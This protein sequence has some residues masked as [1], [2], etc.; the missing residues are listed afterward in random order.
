MHDIKSSNVLLPVHDDTCS[1]HVTPTSD[2]NNVAGVELDIIGDFALLEVELDCVVDPDQG[3]GV[4]DSSAVVRDDM[5]DTLGTNGY[6]ADLQELVR[7]FLRCDAMDSE[8]AFDIV[9]ETEV[10]AR[11]L[12]RNDIYVRRL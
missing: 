6:P 4:A 7:G 10:L 12:N 2:H 9:E 3:V 11:F 8:P 1:A 5:R